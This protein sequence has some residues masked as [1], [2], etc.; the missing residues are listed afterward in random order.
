MADICQSYGICLLDYKSDNICNVLL[1]LFLLHCIPTLMGQ[2]YG[3]GYWLHNSGSFQKV[4]GCCSTL[5]EGGVRSGSK[6]QRWTGLHPQGK[7]HQQIHSVYYILCDN[8]RAAKEA[9]Q[10]IPAP[11]GNWRDLTCDSHGYFDESDDAIGHHASTV[12]RS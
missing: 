12:D 2:G 9:V 7:S 3:Y 1:Y 4:M 5:G 6:R 8:V 10:A 11:D